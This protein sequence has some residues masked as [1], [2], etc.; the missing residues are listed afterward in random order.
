MPGRRFIDPGALLATTHEVG[1][2]A[3]VR[4]RLS[5]PSDTQR[6]RSFLEGFGPV[7]EHLVRRLAYFDPRERLVVVATAPIDR[8]EAILGIADVVMPATGRAELELVVDH[9]LQ[10]RRVGRLLAEAAD[11]LAARR[12]AA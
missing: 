2:G 4:L 7:P 12:R 6:V 1:D 10:G 3:R 5:R 11:T 9:G 8:S